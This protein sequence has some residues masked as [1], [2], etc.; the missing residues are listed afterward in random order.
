[1]LYWLTLCLS[2]V[3][4]AGQPDSSPD[5][6]SGQADRKASGLLSAAGYPS[7]QQALDANPG[8]MLYLPAADY[9][10]EQALVIRTDGSG[11]HGPGRILQANSNAAIIRIEH[12]QRVQL[13]DL[14]LSRTPGNLETTAEGILVLESEEVVLD[15]VRVLDNRS[16]AA[17]IAI[18]ACRGCQLRHCLIQN[19]MRIAVDDRTGSPDWGYA[20]R[21]IDG[22]GIV[23]TESQATRIEGNRLV[24][25]H[26]LPTVE[27]QQQY[28]LGSF[29]K[30]NREKGALVNQQ[31]WEAG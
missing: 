26:L 14:T 13:R 4:Q 22:S 31:V 10:I 8:K 9:V 17:A 16:R 19:Y 1:M 23:V 7:I 11:L 5:V 27:V 30:K 12:A 2:L 29:V 28:D 15:N 20:F 21:C 18:R 6:P 25:R 24:E 3:V